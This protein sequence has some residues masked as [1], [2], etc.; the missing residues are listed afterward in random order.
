M[1]SAQ[2]ARPLAALA[3]ESFP[4]ACPPD[5]DPADVEQFIASE[6][7]ADSFLEFLADPNGHVLVCET[8]SHLAAYA[9]VWTGPAARPP[10]G[11]A[12]SGGRLA[13]LS[14]FYLR[15][16]LV[17]S[18]L[19]AELLEGVVEVGRGLG[20]DTLWLGTGQHNERALRFYEKHGFAR[21]GT[22]TFVVGGRQCAD[23]VLVRRV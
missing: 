23:H 14:K 11:S 18:G 3:A 22:R 5:M 16:G 2:D 7:T 9:L 10:L 4:L 19:A 20:C 1:A 17:G 13:H 12:V 15:P 6:L 8:G 21:V